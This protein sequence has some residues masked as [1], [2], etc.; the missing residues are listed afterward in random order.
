M[1]TL[2][3]KALLPLLSFGK[4]SNLALLGDGSGVV[5]KES[6]PRVVMAV[7]AARTE[8]FTRFRL[9]DKELQLIAEEGRDIYYLRPAHAFNSGVVGIPKYLVDPVDDPFTGGMARIE[10]VFNPRGQ[11]M[12]INDQTDSRNAVYFPEHDAL[13]LVDPKTGDVYRIVYRYA[14][15]H[16]PLSTDLDA[17]EFADL[18]LGVPDGY[19]EAFLLYIGH[20]IY[21]TMNGQDS[22]LKSA[23]Y[24][25]AFEAEC[26]RRTV[27]NTDLS[28]QSDTNERFEIGGWI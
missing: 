20:Q 23:E 9:A 18:D 24:L 28:N 7:N 14:P 27:Q 10:S 16:L 21:S 26:L 15:T 13:R 22:I 17:P 19:R 8:L 12:R 25:S 3:F 4:L 6:Y 1:S 2:T 11:V 5:P